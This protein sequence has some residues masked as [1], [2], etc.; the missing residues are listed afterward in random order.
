MN[1]NEEKFETVSTDIGVAAI[2]EQLA[3][4]STELAQAALKL[5]RIERGENPTPV[6][7]NVAFSNLLEET[8][9]VR[10]CIK[11]L[12]SVVG[13]MDTASIENAKLTRWAARIKATQTEAEQK[14][15][16]K[17]EPRR[18]VIFFTI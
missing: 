3:E 13:N 8:A 5:A 7:A 2:L 4:E 10:L 15:E 11:V 9:D 16:R 17:N 6:P 12:E 1:T 18:R 14:P